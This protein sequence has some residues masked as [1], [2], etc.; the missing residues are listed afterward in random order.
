M[1]SKNMQRAFE[2]VYGDTQVSPDELIRLCNAVDEAAMR[3]LAQEGQEG[4]LA[5]TINFR[6]HP[7]RPA[8]A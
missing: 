7:C 4:V 1:I 3:V 6:D 2:M 5:N 8:E